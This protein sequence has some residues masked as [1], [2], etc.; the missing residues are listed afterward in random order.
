[1]SHCVA[2]FIIS[3]A[4]IF[5]LFLEA[6]G[7]PDSVK[8][9]SV[10]TRINGKLLLTGKLDDPR[11]NLAQPVEL[12]YEVTPGENTPSPQRTSV[13]VLYDD[14]NIYFGFECADTHPSEIRA[15]VTDRDKPYDDDFV[16]VILDTYGDFQ[17]SYEFLVNPYGVQADLLRTSNNEDDSFDTVWESAATIDSTGWTAEMAIPFKSLR[18]PAQSTQKWVA[19]YIRNYPRTSRVQTSWVKVDRNNPC[20]TCQGGTIEGIHDIQSS[21]ASVDLLPYVLGKQSSSLTDEDDPQS[22]FE[23]GKVTGRVGGSIRYAPTADFAVEGVINPDFSQVESDATQISVNSNF[24]LFYPEKRPF[25]LLGADLF[26]N[27]T[28]TYYSRAINNP[29]GA[30][31]IIGKSGSL[32]FAYLAASDRNTPFIIPGEETSDFVATDLNSLSNVAR[33]RYDFGKEIFI[34]GMLMA[35]NTGS[36]AHNYLGGVDW[37]YKFWE[38]FYFS[39]ELF[40]SDTKELNDTTLLANSRT[41]GSTG[42]DATFNGEQYDG[43][44]ALVTI[45]RNA[46]NYSFSLQYS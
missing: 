4:A 29:L 15:H 23:G 7:A 16:L 46:R 34:G 8:A 43:T 12:P 18:F 27:N 13:R 10:A 26:Q 32:S 37:N 25:F 20:L 42:H 22:S 19:E 11:W 39:G 33:V 1:M 9:S 5:G 40:Y 30:G 17:R 45:Q 38:N 3:A 6:S 2:R 14:Q 31:R 35:R 44:S 24:A 41:F 28:T 21:A 36:S